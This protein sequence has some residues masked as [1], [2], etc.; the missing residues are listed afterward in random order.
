M[1]QLFDRFIHVEFNLSATN[2][3]PMTK[4]NFK[5]PV[6]GVKPNI[7]VMFNILPDSNVNEL[8]LRLTNF[9]SEIN[10]AQYKRLKIVAGYMNTNKAPILYTTIIGDI[11]DCFIEKPN[12]E[13]ITIFRC[14]IGEIIDMY[15]IKKP[16]TTSFAAG[17]TVDSALRKV[18]S[19][20]KYESRIYLPTDWKNIVFTDTAFQQT[21]KNALGAYTWLKDW[22]RVVAEANSLKNLHIS[23]SNKRLYCL[24]LD[25]K[26]NNESAIVIDKVA[27]AYLSGKAVVVTAPWL[28]TLTHNALFKMNTKYFRGRIGN[29]QITGKQKLFRVISNK[30]TFST[31]DDNSMEVYG[32]DVSEE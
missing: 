5:T 9:Y 10:I 1:S 4:I 17:D 18:A 21:F 7:K 26:S 15:D 11:M 19:A 31:Y 8:T 28:P 12:P 30:V 3:S 20:F 27:N 2:D 32:F 22:L 14:V 23:L 16:V 13:G 25:T 6:T 29:L 24:S